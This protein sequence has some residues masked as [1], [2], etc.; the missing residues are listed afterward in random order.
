MIYKKILLNTINENASENSYI[1]MYLHEEHE[2][3][4]KERPAI[5]IVPG[6][7]Y[8]SLAPLEAG[9]VALRYA[10]EGFNTFV[11]WYGINQEYPVPHQDLLI[12]LMH[13]KLHKNEYGLDGKYFLMGFSAGGH[14]VGSYSYLYKELATKFDVNEEFLRPDAII[15]SYPVITMFENTHIRTRDI[16][17]GFNELNYAKLSIERNITSDYPPTFVWHTITDTGVSVYNSKCL[18]EAL[19]ANDVI[20]EAHYFNFL[21]HGR[22]V[23][24]MEIKEQFKPFTEEEL[25]CKT[26]VDLSINFLM[27]NFY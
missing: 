6:G 1:E 8:F 27:K 4:F 14:L 3:V 2:G 5:L 7:G 10:S 26:W 19:K 17:S 15:L 16:I 12:A 18:E 13:I 11:L 23:M 20:H 24:T 9:T 25:V 22:S 21:D